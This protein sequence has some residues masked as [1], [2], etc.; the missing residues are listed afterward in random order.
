MCRGEPDHRAVPVRERRANH[1]KT[2]FAELREEFRSESEACEHLKATL[3][4]IGGDDL[5][6]S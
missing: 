6:A 4:N 1:P 2:V 5:E 3:A